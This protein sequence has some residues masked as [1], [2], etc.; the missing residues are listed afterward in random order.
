MSWHLSY[1]ILYL[2]DTELI[3]TTK[4]KINKTNAARLLDKAKIAYDLIP[5]EVDEND[6]ME[7]RKIVSKNAEPVKIENTEPEKM[8][9]D[10][11]KEYKVRGEEDGNE[12]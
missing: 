3:N 1:H 11:P 10:E 6:M 4:M 8:V 9:F 7:L 2:S 5:Y 12:I